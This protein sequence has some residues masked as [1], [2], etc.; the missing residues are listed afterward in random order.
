M[1]QRLPRELRVIYQVARGAAAQSSS[2]AAVR[3]LCDELGAQFG[4]EQV[5]FAGDDAER[6]D[7]VLLDAALEAGPAVVCSSRVAIP[8]LVDGSCIG[9]LLADSGGK[10]L[11]LGRHDLDLLST[12]GLVGGV[13]VA[14]AQQYEE[15]Q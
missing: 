2:D 8:L 5:R 14:K 3:H 9:Y 12:L 7:H 10:P 1:P 13:I 15:L 4:F 11:E 6:R